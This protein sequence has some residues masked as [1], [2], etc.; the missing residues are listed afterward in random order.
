MQLVLISFQNTDMLAIENW[1]LMPSLV[2]A[3]ERFRHN[4]IVAAGRI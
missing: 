2:V 1:H 3:G 4:A